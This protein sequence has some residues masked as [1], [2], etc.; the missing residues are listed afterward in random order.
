MTILNILLQVDPEHFKQATPYSWGIYTVLV[1]CL[2]AAIVFVWR[3]FVNVIKD[4][5]KEK[6]DA[7]IY[8]QKKIEELEASGK[9]LAEKALIVITEVK[10]GILDVKDHRIEV[11]SKLNNLQT[12][13]NKIINKP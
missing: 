7:E 11:I 6:T 2:A 10:V 3:Y 4:I 5:K 1:T 12:D 9:E 13:M 8:Y